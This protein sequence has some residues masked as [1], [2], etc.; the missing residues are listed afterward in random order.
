MSVDKVKRIAL[1]EENNCNVGEMQRP[2]VKRQQGVVFSV[3]QDVQEYSTRDL[4]REENN[5]LNKLSDRKLTS[6]KNLLFVPVSDEEINKLAVCDINIS[7]AEARHKGTLSDARLGPSSPYEL[8]ITCKS[9]AG[10]CIGH[11][12][13]IQLVK[14]MINPLFKTETFLTLECVC[15]YCGH[16]YLNKNDVINNGIDKLKGKHRLK[17]IAELSVKNEYMNRHENCNENPKYINKKN[18]YDICFKEGNIIKER[19]PENIVNIF[20]LLTKE[21]LKILGYD[22]THPKNFIMNSILVTPSVRRPKTYIGGGIDVITQIYMSIIDENNALRSIVNREGSFRSANSTDAVM[23]QS[24]IYQLYDQLQSNKDGKKGTIAGA[25]NE[26]SEGLLT[27]IGG[28]RGIIRM[29]CLGVRPDYSGRSVLGPSDQEYKYILTPMY[30]RSRLTTREVVTKYSIGRLTEMYLKGEVP[31]IIVSRGLN[32]VNR[33]R[34]DKKTIENYQLKIGDEVERFTM[35]G[36][37]CYFGRQPTIQRQCLEGYM[38]KFHNKDTIGLHQ[39]CNG[40]HNADF[41]G[42]EGTIHVFQNTAAKIEALTVGSVQTNIMSNHSS[43]PM[44]APAFNSIV[45]VYIMTTL[46]ETDLDISDDLWKRALNEC[47]NV[48]SNYYKNDFDVY[49]NTIRNKFVKYNVKEKT[50]RGLYSLL[51]PPDFEMKTRDLI[52]EK[53]IV[54]VGVPNYMKIKNND[55]LELYQIFSSEFMFDQ[56]IEDKLTLEEV[57]TKRDMTIPDY[58]IERVMDKLDDE[59]KSSTYEKRCRN[60]GINSKSK[61]ALISLAFPPTLNY[62]KG[63]IQVINGIIVSGVL[64]KGNIGT[65]VNSFVKII[66]KLYNRKESEK[67]INNIQI[68]TDIFLEWAGFSIGFSACDN[69]REDVLREVNTEI[70]KS[71]ALLLNLGREPESAQDKYFHKKKKFEILNNTK[72]IGKKIGKRNL[73]E[74]N[75][76][77]ILGSKGSGA[78]GND[79]NTAQI[80][81]SLGEQFS[82]GDLPPKNLNGGARSQVFFTRDDVSL[83]SSGYITRSFYDGLRPEEFVPH[84]TSSREG[85]IDTAANTGKFGYLHRKVKKSNEDTILMNTGSVGTVRGMVFQP[86]CNN[87]ISPGE[88]VLVTTKK[89]GSYLSFVDCK[90]LAHQLNSQFKADKVDRPIAEVEI[91]E[92]SPINRDVIENVDPEKEVNLNLPGDAETNN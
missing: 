87:F 74:C 72:E 7:S 45:G 34:V 54:N 38:I 88:S 30:M 23:A 44:I 86:S 6:I 56:S 36:D 63:D 17:K 2:N 42:D 69:N 12:G 14:P 70:I 64:D 47:F 33:R 31:F 24:N 1:K 60:V 55:F 65:S 50:A 79:T 26:K 58:L 67:F 83:M 52:I 92:L 11:Y 15:A 51:L 73:K 21:E 68:I 4:A 19:S 41:D 29:N 16:I 28:K 89:Y 32:K 78:K 5:T 49:Y 80:T 22:H 59:K 66:G 85:L 84:A 71:Q 40:K 48:Y 75:P 91:E 37:A 46:W 90:M 27:R 82:A 3:K 43:R 57:M 20:S 62:K 9:R 35:D 10:D 13:K 25:D 77:N 8:C 18:Q 81:G 61:R 53:G 39:S 76:L